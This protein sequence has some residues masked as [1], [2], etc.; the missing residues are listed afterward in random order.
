VLTCSVKPVGRREETAADSSS[1][2]VMC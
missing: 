2:N 1:S